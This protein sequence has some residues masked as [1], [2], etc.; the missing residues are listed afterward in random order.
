MTV[1]LANHPEDFTAVQD[2]R[3]RYSVR[4]T[5]KHLCGAKGCDF[6][7]EDS[8]N[9]AIKSRIKRTQGSV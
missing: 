8:R 4:I 3:T 5:G 9:W 2:L 7:W 6:T 1:I